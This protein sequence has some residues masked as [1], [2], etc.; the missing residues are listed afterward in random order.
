MGRAGRPT[1]GDDLLVESRGG[2]FG[3]RPDERYPR[4]HFRGRLTSP[5]GFDRLVTVS[6]GVD[7]PVALWST[8]AGEAELHAVL[9][10]PATGTFPRRTPDGPPPAVLTAHDW[11]TLAITASALV[12]ELPVAHPFVEVLPDGTFLLVGARCAWQPT[13]PERN[14][15]AIDARGDVVHRGCLGDGI[16]HLQ[17]APDGSIWVGYFDEGVFGNLGWGIPGPAPLG[18]G[19]IATWSADFAKTWELDPQQGLIADCYSLNVSADE[20]LACSYTDFPIVR[21]NND[22]VEVLPT[23]EVSGPSAVL[24]AG[25]RVALIGDYR[26]PALLIIGDTQDGTVR[27][28]QRRHLWA[29]TGDPLPACKVHCR[30]SVAHFFI[31]PD[32]YTFD[33]AEDV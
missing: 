11:D 30:G 29:P 21:I 18:A 19:G 8:A 13:G 33:L 32:W 9:G 6:A 22:H 20:V 5:Q 27:E 25:N 17:V 10:S 4:V 14:A 28:L 7:G 24:A 23:N 16:A 26:D 12:E 31:D 1:V 3:G 15:L 2:L